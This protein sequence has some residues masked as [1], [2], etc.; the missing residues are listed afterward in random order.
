MSSASAFISAVARESRLAQGVR[1][2]H[3][4]ALCEGGSGGAN[5]KGNVCKVRTG[6]TPGFQPLGELRDRPAKPKCIYNSKSAFLFKGF[7]VR[8]P[9]D[10]P[11]LHAQLVYVE[12]CS[13]NTS[14]TDCNFFY[15]FICTYSWSALR[16]KLLLS[17]III[18]INAASST[19]S[20]RTHC[21]Q[22]DMY[23]QSQRTL[24][25]HHRC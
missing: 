16:C 10:A 13:I 8:C 6:P 12:Q 20:I 2:A 25:S 19:N 11:R 21:Q 24:M 3:W 5:A 22:H 9:T 23:S 1:G 4:H 14:V 15:I 18:I 7:N 17:V